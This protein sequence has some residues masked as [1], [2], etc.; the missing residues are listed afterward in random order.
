M[1]GPWREFGQTTSNAALSFF[2]G[3]VGGVDGEYI[4]FQTGTQSRI[5]FSTSRSNI[6]IYTEL[7]E[8]KKLGYTS[9]SIN[10]YVEST[11][12]LGYIL[13]GGAYTNWLVCFEQVLTN[14][15]WNT[16]ELSIDTLI[17]WYGD[18]AI[19]LGSSQI[20][21]FGFTNENSLESS[22]YLADVLYKK[23]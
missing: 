23:S 13:Y 19:G 4:K 12:T 7:T 22:I 21:L 17:T 8:M 14:N 2:S 16:V 11:G 5:A 9:I 6:D 10:L 15:S 18:N 3:I 20:A 1:T